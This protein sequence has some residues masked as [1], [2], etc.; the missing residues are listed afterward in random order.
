MYQPNERA[1]EL[2]PTDRG[3]YEIYD[4]PI[5]SGK[6][7]INI[8]DLGEYKTKR[9][10]VE[11]PGRGTREETVLYPVCNGPDDLHL[12]QSTYD[13]P[14]PKT[15]ETAPIY[16]SWLDLP[17][18]PGRF[19]MTIAPGKKADGVSG[20]WDR[21][22][23]TD[24]HRLKEL[25]VTH[26]GCLIPENELA[27]LKIPDLSAQAQKS[28]IH[29]L[30]FPFADGGVPKSLE[31]LDDFL[32]TLKAAFLEKAN[33]VVHCRGGL[34]RSGLVAACFL[35]KMGVTDNWEEAM[36]LVRKARSRNAIEKIGQEQFIKR[37]AER[38]AAERQGGAR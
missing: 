33:I 11:Y 12:P 21:D 27:F 25:G 13:R 20:E 1:Y 10:M 15:S 34:G 35:L 23:P 2:F 36:R 22:L 24:L 14:F 18:Q 29:F 28:G 16:V 3:T 9:V 6:D 37:Y 5:Y 31:P 4:P 8:E 38:C 19:G 26:L 7:V 32:E 17:D 30:E